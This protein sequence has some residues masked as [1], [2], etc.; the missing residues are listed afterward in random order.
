MPTLSIHSH[1]CADITDGEYCLLFDP[2]LIGSA[3][4]RSWWNFPEPSDFSA[5]CKRLIRY[6]VVYVYITH[7][8]WDHFHAPTIRRL[9]NSLPN[10]H[11]LIPK[12]PE[13]RLANDLRDVLPRNVHYQEIPQ[14]SIFYVSENFYFK[15]FL[16]GFFV[17]DSA[18]LVNIGNVQVLN[19]NDSKPLN[20]LSKSIK[21]SIN[22][23][24]LITL[25][26][27]SSANA[28]V[29]RRLRNGDMPIQSQD[30]LNEYS[31]Q[32]IET[33]KFFRTNI[34]IPF[35]SNMCYLHKDTFQYNKHSNT[36]DVVSSFALEHDITFV[37]LVL[38]R[39]NLDLDTLIV[40][41]D[42][43]SRE[44]LFADRDTQLLDYRLRKISSLE[45]TDRMSVSPIMF[46]RLVTHYFAKFFSTLPCWYSLLLSSGVAF[47]PSHEFVE[48]FSFTVIP[49]SNL[50][51]WSQ[52]DFSSS[53]SCIVVP[54]E[55]LVSILKTRN[56][57][58]LGIS[59]RVLICADHYGYYRLF[60]A[61]LVYTDLGVFP[62]TLRTIYR[63]FSSWIWRAP[64]ILDLI[65]LAL[66]LK[67]KSFQVDSLNPSKE[68]K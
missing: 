30:S 24:L 5:L 23:D 22:K 62:L 12:V 10:L 11:F 65:S 7:L 68:S 50:V 1:G 9:V 2:W 36:A 4:W 46:S 35:A 8:H 42:K 63:L 43:Q 48:G 67:I 17:T 51:S 21:S 19:L 28:R 6:K 32:F 18:V 61:A 53:K 33:A 34:A 49:F 57:D 66:K 16:S 13:I 44:Q 41:M 45:C 25:R 56:F 20:I 55:V 37:K 60:L 26:S 52:V 47:S 39:E 3:Y 29:C 59:K 27:H 14:N 58:S 40:N 54:L 31:R 64:E 38:P 15:I